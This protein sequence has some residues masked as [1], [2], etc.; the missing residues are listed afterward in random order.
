MTSISE[1]TSLLTEFF[2]TAGFEE[3]STPEIIPAPVPE[4]HIDLFK[5]DGGYKRPSPEVEMKIYL[6]RYKK[7]IFQIGSCFRKEEIGKHHK[8]Q[9]TMLE[10]YE[11]GADYNDTLRLTQKLL[12]FLTKKLYKSSF[13]TYNNQ[14]IDLAKEWSVFTVEEAFQKFAN[15]ASKTAIAEDKFEERLVDYVE[16]ELSYSNTP[17]ILKDYPAKFAALA[18]L[19]GS[20]KTVAE[21]WELYIGGIEL[22]NTYSELTDPNENRARFAKFAEDRKE[23]GKKE[24]PI[25]EEFF[26][27][28]DKGMPKSSGCAMGLDRL[29]MLLNNQK[30][31]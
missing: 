11:V 7:S 14:S 18:K 20:D 10:W 9:F 23:L 24:I 30:T 29:T 1:I 5:V 17:V 3:V 26:N 31:I 2:I 6:S 19:K 15:I 12:L 21:R 28:L 13:I 22:A 4:P 16:P 8:E 25:S 27:A